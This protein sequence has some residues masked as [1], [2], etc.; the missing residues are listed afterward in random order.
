MLG[1][2]EEVVVRWTIRLLLTAFVAAIMAVVGYQLMFKLGPDRWRLDEQSAL[3]VLPSVA[4]WLM[5]A[6]ILHR[7]NYLTAFG[8][9]LLSPL[10]GSLFVA[11]LAGPAIVLAMWYVAF[12]V[13]IVTGFLVKFCVSG[14]HSTA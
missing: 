3:L 12:P 7:Q 2:P 13:G 4:L 1:E 14:C 8:W 11:W 10:I 6:L 5:L 9:G